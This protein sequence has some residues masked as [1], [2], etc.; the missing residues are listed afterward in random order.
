M[1]ARTDDPAAELGRRVRRQQWWAL[2]AVALGLLMV[3]SAPAITLEVT[4]GCLLAGGGVGLW[5]GL[6]GRPH[7]MV[8]GDHATQVV[9][10]DIQT[11]QQ[12]FS[13]LRGQV[14]STIR[15]SEAAVLA[16]MQRLS[17]VHGEATRL[18]ERV[19]EAALHSESLT[20][21][22][23]RHAAE[24]AEAAATLA[25]HQRRLDDE[26][27]RNLDRVRAVSEQV[28]RLQ[29]LV[30]VVADVARQTN[31]LAINAAIEAAR[32]GPGGAGFKVVA[33]EVRVLSDR[34]AHAAR[35]IA[36]GIGAAA[37]AIDAEVLNSLSESRADAAGQLDAIGSHIRRTADALQHV[38]PYLAGLSGEMN[39]G[40]ARVD[41]DIV[42]T[43]GDMQFQDINRQLLEQIDAAMASMSEHFSQ[44]YQLIDGQAPPPPVLLEELL[45]RWAADYVMQVQRD[46]HAR[47]VGGAPDAAPPAAGAAPVSAG[48]PAIEL[49]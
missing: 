34:A 47:A 40:M 41:S 42:D 29:P 26:A 33:G 8:R 28:R 46:D 43:L 36:E 3:T 27:G 23:A 45:E 18:R 10:Q 32:A 30:A 16:M 39:E 17:R 48:A 13:V 38:V 9:A 14:G 12:A 37:A 2:A 15:T 6:R 22:A 35:G 7:G 24:D 49:F 31:L 19:A 1:H 44:V 5:I 4:L 25:V 20:Q 11:L 21:D